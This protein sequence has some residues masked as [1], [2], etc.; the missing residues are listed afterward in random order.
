M[1]GPRIPLWG[2]LSVVDKDQDNWP[3]PEISSIVWTQDH[4]LFDSYR[5]WFTRNLSCYS[6][7]AVT[8]CH[9]QLTSK[10]QFIYPCLSL[11]LPHIHT[12]KYWTIASKLTNRESLY[13]IFSTVCHCDKAAN[14]PA[15][16]IDRVSEIVALYTRKAVGYYDTILN[17][18]PIQYGLSHIF[19]PGL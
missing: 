3:P 1:I 15:P 7:N 13:I 19:G 14:F 11:Q 12:Q 8:G 17:V 4:F 18:I 9:L 5:L 2:T 6:P 16:K 10:T